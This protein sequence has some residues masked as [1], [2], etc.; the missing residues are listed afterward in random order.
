MT[1]FWCVLAVIESDFM[2]MS[3]ATDVCR[4]LKKLAAEPEVQFN[5][6]YATKPEVGLGCSLLCII[7]LRLSRMFL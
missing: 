5:L 1:S 4:R 6:Y 7:F 3:L 2:P